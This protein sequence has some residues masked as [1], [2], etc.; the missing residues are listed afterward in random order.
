MK[1]TR[2][3][4]VETGAADG[5]RLPVDEQRLGTDVSAEDEMLH[6]CGNVERDGVGPRLFDSHRVDGSGWGAGAPLRAVTPVSARRADPRHPLRL[7]ENVERRACRV[8]ERPAARYQRV[9]GAD[10]VDLEIAECRHAGHRGDGRS[11]QEITVGW[12]CADR[13]RDVVGGGRDRIAVL[14]LNLHL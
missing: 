13:D 12:I 3:I 7:Y 10:V 1:H 11:A 4:D 2:R 6:G 8:G 5:Q 14:I 9:A